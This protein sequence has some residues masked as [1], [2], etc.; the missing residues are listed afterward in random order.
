ML[1]ELGGSSDIQEKLRE[2]TRSYFDENNAIDLKT[3]DHIPYLD[4]VVREI[5][6]LYPAIPSLL[7]SINQRESNVAL[8]DYQLEKGRSLAMVIWTANRHPD[9]WYEATSFIPE[10]WDPKRQKEFKT[11]P[12]Y[13][14]SFGKGPN[15]CLGEHLARLELKSLI[16]EMVNRCCWKREKEVVFDAGATLCSVEPIAITI[17]SL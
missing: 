7:R 4:W 8:G 10:R 17:D 11:D 13:M 5:F 6:R 3:L 14:L 15:K 1:Y 2:A 9:Y 12:K 16:F